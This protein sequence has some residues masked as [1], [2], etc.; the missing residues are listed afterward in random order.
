MGRLRN[1]INLF[2]YLGP[3]PENIPLPLHFSVLYRAEIPQLG[4]YSLFRNKFFLLQESALPLLGEGREHDF[5]FSQ[6]QYSKNMS[7]FA[8]TFLL[9][10]V[11]IAQES[12]NH[13]IHPDKDAAKRGIRPIIRRPHALIL[14]NAIAMC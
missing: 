9:R 5:Y 13:F 3:D 12:N 4:T 14:F 8:G 6:K 11:I 1:F 10:R 7:G 2:P